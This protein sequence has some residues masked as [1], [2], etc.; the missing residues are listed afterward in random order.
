M[1]RRRIVKAI[2]PLF[3]VGIHK[4]YREKESQWAGTTIAG[5]TF[6]VLV[7]TTLRDHRT[8]TREGVGE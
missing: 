5:L 8:E 3:G 6:N 2:A 1:P 7:K 4:I